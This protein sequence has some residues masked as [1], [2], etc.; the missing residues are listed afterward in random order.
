M[1]TSSIALTAGCLLSALAGYTPDCAAQMR[2]WGTYYGGGFYEDAGK[3]A[4]D[5]FGN[6]YIVG[7]TRSD[8]G[9][10]TP[11]GF[12][13]LLGN[14][15]KKG[16]LA[17]FNTNGHLVW[18]TYYGDGPISKTVDIGMDGSGNIIVMGQVTCPSEALATPNAAFTACIGGTD[19]FL[20]K[21]SPNGDRLWG[22]YVGGDV[23]ETAGGISVTPYGD[24]YVIGTTSSPRRIAILPSQ[25]ATL[26]GTHD[27]FV[28]KFNSLGQPVWSRYYGGEN[29]EQ[30]RDISCKRISPS[31]ADR[32]Y[33]TGSTKSIGGIASN[34]AHDTAL[35]GGQDAFIAMLDGNNGQ[36]LWGTYY[37]GN[38][39]DAGTAVVAGPG[40]YFYVGGDTA[41]AD[42]M[43]TPN[44][45]DPSYNGTDMFV[46]RFSFAGARTAGSY[47]GGDF[48]TD[49]LD[50]L[51]VD[52]GDNLY[53]TG[54]VV[55]P[56]SYVTAGAYDT[57]LDGATDLV[58]AKF[59]PQLIREWATYY[60]GN[61]VENGYLAV[62]KN[63]HIYLSG[64][65]NSHDAIASPGSHKEQMEP[66]PTTNDSFLVEMMP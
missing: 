16:Y 17:K 43:S 15:T 65:T 10:A 2:L 23:D 27:A 50:D 9:I 1:K 34:G 54:E 36:R 11:N 4:A 19:L 25:D 44:A 30:G 7:E 21:F 60:G 63:N 45:Y 32:C 37:G 39:I 24:T 53:L 33:I 57:A 51:A 35:N 56:G 20:A 40:L 18:A 47:F 52:A 6:V 42:A 3:V 59:N 46:A 58:L 28:I 5:S 62:D 61:K 55:E 22:T 14:A 66:S 12:D 41:S 38:G 49:H 31:A 8:D 48:Y 64:F 29:V 13:P 26:D